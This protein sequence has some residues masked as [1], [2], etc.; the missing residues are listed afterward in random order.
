MPYSNA[1]E[2]ALRELVLGNHILADHGV[3]DAYGHLSMRHPE[4]PDRYFLSCSR[5]PEQVA[6]EDFIEF[7]L[8]STPVGDETRAMYAERPIH[9]C[10]YAARPDVNSV[11]HNHAPASVPFGVTGTPM[12]PI[13]HVAAP[14]GYE[15]ET[16]DIMD[17]FGATDLLV[18]T[19]AM[20]AS[21]AAKLGPNT[22]ILMRGHGSTV[23]TASVRATVMTA[24]YLQENAKVL[25]T[26]LLMNPN[27]TYLAREEVEK[28]TARQVT[29]LALNR[30]WNAWVSRLDKS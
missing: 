27:V 10:I 22:S 6:L 4:R 13:W 5:A 19:E 16:W 21:L 14:I 30:A 25:S 7:N 8:D 17:E 18:V 3:V 28:A 1:V 12:R 26:A 2:E 20:G 24:V 15:V 29:P 9:G 11:C 23:A